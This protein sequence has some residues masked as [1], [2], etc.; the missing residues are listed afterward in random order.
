MNNKLKNLSVLWLLTTGL[1]LSFS[2]YAWLLSNRVLGFQTFNI[3]IASR[4][5]L[6][7]SADGLEWKSVITLTDLIR[8]STNY[9]A[10]RNQIP[11]TINPVSTTGETFNG[12]L[13]FFS[14]KA[15]YSQ[16]NDNMILVAKESLESPG[17]GEEN[18]SDYISF[19]LF[20]KNQTRMMLNLTPLSTIEAMQ[21][22]TGIENAF[23][24]AFLNQGTVTLAASL[25]NIQTLS[26]ATK[27]IMWEPNYNI[28]TNGGVLN[29]RNNYGLNISNQS[30]RIT[31]SGIREEIVSQDNISLIRSNANYFPSK[32]RTVNI[33]IPTAS[34]FASEQPIMILEKGITKITLYI[35]IE[36]QDIDCE[37]NA[38][39]SSVL[40]N[41]Q[42]NAN[43]L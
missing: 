8:S 41:L 12:R 32:F 30:A 2:T 17:F 31:Y 14:G 42:L 10:N 6:E 26:G 25:R 16:T 9:P 5:G 13:N 35:W 38:S 28:H 21:T 33:D 19:D 23:R 34:N 7:I 37:D 1:M 27:A 29:A 36:G 40:I 20:F 3:Q 39:I 4:G 24:V 43:Y 22:S 11:T 18:A 15:V